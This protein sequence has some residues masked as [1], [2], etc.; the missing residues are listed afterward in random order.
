MKNKNR[1]IFSNN[2]K[3]YNLLHLYI[4]KTSLMLL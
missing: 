1:K 3:K 2:L 4:F